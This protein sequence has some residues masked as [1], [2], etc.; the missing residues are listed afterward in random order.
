MISE[1]MPSG[2]LPIS[3]DADFLNKYFLRF[4]E[5]GE[6][7]E[8]VERLIYWCNK[9]KFP[10]SKTESEYIKTRKKYLEYYNSIRL[11][12]GTF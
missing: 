6:R 7:K 1:L 4:T 9:N 2:H 3:V 12:D 5:Q 8:G 11:I 10:Y